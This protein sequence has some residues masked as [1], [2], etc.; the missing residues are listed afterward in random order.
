MHRRSNLTRQK[1]V[2]RLL[3][4]AV[5]LASCGGVSGA[6][7]AEATLDEKL[8][9]E[10]PIEYLLRRF[11]AESYGY[12]FCIQVVDLEVLHRRFEL[13]APNSRDSYDDYFDSVLPIVGGGYPT[14]PHREAT[15]PDAWESE[16]GVS[17]LDSRVIAFYDGGPE[18][19]ATFFLGERDIDEVVDAM[20]AD[21]YWADHHQIEQV[22]AGYVVVFGDD[23]TRIAADRRSDIRRLGQG[24]SALVLEPFVAWGPVP[25]D[26]MRS[27]AEPSSSTPVDDP[28]V[29]ELIETIE[30]DGAYSW[31]IGQHG[32]GMSRCTGGDMGNLLGTIQSEEIDGVAVGYS[33]NEADEPLVH[34]GVH[35]VSEPT[36]DA[37]RSVRSLMGSDSALPDGLMGFGL[38]EVEFQV[39]GSLIRGSWVRH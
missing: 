31:S 1:Y 4:G 2:A 15:Y 9:D 24:G 28:I 3:I 10:S 20:I 38:R 25:A 22:A 23:P 14:A 33:I 27:V 17:E 32:M 26:F 30:V 11:P 18:T 29:K 36:E 34:V 12:G 37:V 35:F 5:A 8:A 6:P 19:S 21:D 7:A 13:A 39:D 16:L